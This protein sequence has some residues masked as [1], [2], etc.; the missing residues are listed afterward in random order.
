M[1]DDGTPALGARQKRASPAK[2]TSGCH[3]ASFTK[4]FRLGKWIH[5]RARPA[6]G[7]KIDD[8]GRCGSIRGWPFS[9][10][11]LLFSWLPCQKIGLTRNNATTFRASEQPTWGT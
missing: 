4:T 1:I 9:R 11:P 3:A 5:Y 8:T 2:F 10:F 6:L 7:L